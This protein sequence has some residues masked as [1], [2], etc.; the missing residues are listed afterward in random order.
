MLDTPTLV[1]TIFNVGS[2]LANLGLLVWTRIS[3]TAAAA[4]VETARDH[5]NEAKRSA[6]AAEKAA[7]AAGKSAEANAVA[8]QMARAQQEQE[9]VELI[10]DKLGRPS[11]VR[12]ILAGLPSYLAPLRCT[13]LKRAMD[14]SKER[15]WYEETDYIGNHFPECKGKTTA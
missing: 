3:A 13:L 10:K 14:Q 8:A 5:L 12:A 9:W 1:A 4:S 11:D 2:L 6:S 15:Q 7:E